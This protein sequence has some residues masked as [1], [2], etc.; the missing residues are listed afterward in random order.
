MKVNCTFL[1]LLYFIVNTYQIN[2]QVQVD[3][4]KTAQQLAQK[5]AGQGIIISNASL[6]CHNNANGFFQINTSVLPIDSGVVLSTGNVTAIAGAENGATSSNNN[7][8]GDPA[9]QSLSGASI[10]YDACILEFDMVPQGSQVAFDY[11][12]ASEEYINSV[13]GPFND[14]FAFFI[15][16][17]GITGNLNMAK[18]PN[19]T[20]PVTVNSVNNGIPGSQANGS[21]LKCVNMGPGAPFTQYYVDNIGGNDIAYRGLTH[22]FTAAADVI[23]CQTYHLKLTIADAQN[24]LYDSGVFIKAGSLKS[25]AIQ[26]NTKGSFVYQ[27]KEGL[28][29]TCESGLLTF[30][31]NQALPTAQT[32]QLFIGGTAIAGL[33]Y[34]ALP[35]TITIPANSLSVS[36]PVHTLAGSNQL[37]NISIAVSDPFQC[38]SNAIADSTLMWLLPPPVFEILTPDTTICANSPLI[39]T[40]RNADSFI[41]NWTPPNAVSISNGKYIVSGQQSAI[42]RATAMTKYG[43][44]AVQSDSIAITVTAGPLNIQLTDTLVVCGHDEPIITPTVNP[45][46]SAYQYRWT[47]P[48][49]YTY[50][51]AQLTYNKDSM[52]GGW[53]FLVVSQDQCASI[54]DSVFIMEKVS[55]DAP[56]LTSPLKMCMNDS[57]FVSVS[58]DNV[59]FYDNEW[60]SSGL[61]NGFWYYGAYVGTQVYYVSQGSGSCISNKTKLQIDIIECCE[62]EIFVPNAF[63]PNGDGMNDMFQVKT[64]FVTAV[65]QMTIF[66]RWGQTVYHFAGN[67]PV[68][69]GTYNGQKADIGTYFYFVQFQCR[70]GIIK[71]KK[72]EIHLIR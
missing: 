38:T 25:Q 64:D 9:L 59:Q 26:I 5:L 29:Y 56:V 14:A 30:S 16:G 17:P 42:Y 67:Q 72:G 45:L 53:Y 63:S 23:P 65:K 11:V 18:V 52:Q 48:N 27:Q 36:L 10:T 60:S 68:W 2:A 49:A 35:T 19:T 43:N 31:R 24:K 15:S 1:M 46:N 20:I 34:I 61:P 57:L 55:Y 69:D 13:C 44:C 3:P 28:Y 62:N 6:Q 7:T 22:V 12:F 58:G 66:N 33:D 47:G 40:L 8:A 51:G 39:L 21:S 4:N 37:K 54:M 50:N 32:L 41:L 70:D 71:I